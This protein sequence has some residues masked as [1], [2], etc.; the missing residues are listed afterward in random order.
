ME[1]AKAIASRLN[2]SP[3]AR[4]TIGYLATFSYGDASQPQWTGVVDAAR[5]HDVNLICFL[6][7]NLRS[8]TGLEAQGNILYDL[9]SPEN[10][11]G[12]VSWAS[13][14]GNYV[15]AD[16]IRIFHEH[17][18]PL[19]MVT[20]GKIL[21]GIPGLLMDSYE[22]MRDAIVHLIRDHGYR[23]IAF[24]RGPENHLYAQQRYHAYTE[25]LKAYGISLDP[26]L[27]TPHFSWE[28]FRGR[29]AMRLLLDERKLRPQTDFEAIAVA[30][31][32]LLLGALEVLRERG[33]RV[34]WDEAVVGFNDTFQGR[35]NIPPLTTVAVPFYQVGYQS[36]E[37]LLALLEG[38]SVPKQV[39]APSK[40][41]IRQSC[42]C[43][44]PAVA[45]A[46]IDPT[47]V[48]E[49]RGARV[50]AS[51]RDQILS[52]MTQAV[53]ESFENVASGWRDR[54]LDG[55]VSELKGEPSSSFLQELYEVLRQ[56]R[57]AGSDVSA[58]QGALSAL[59]QQVA[60]LLDDE[61]LKRAENLW[62]QARVAI[63]ETAKR[64][65]AYQAL[66]AGQQA[67]TLRDI[68]T[69]LI[70]TFDV[71][72]LMDVLAQDL[73]RLGI[74]SCYLAL[75]ENPLPYRYPQPAPEWSRLA[76]AFTEK[77]RI[78]LEPGGRRFRSREL[79]PAGML[80]QDRPLSLAVESLYFQDNQL[81]FVVVEI[82]P[83]DGAVYA[84]LRAQISSALQGA[85]LQHE[86]QRTQEALKTSQTQLRTI[87]DSL[88]VLIAQVGTDQRFRSVPQSGTQKNITLETRCFPKSRHYSYYTP[89]SE[90]SQYSE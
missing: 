78:P 52:A 68:G 60:P 74:P 30:N 69:A 76:L 7:R 55:F 44:D 33:I 4:R 90:Q 47:Q 38:Q 58:W 25:A 53:G 31:D 67:Q 80:P 62:Q 50:L 40:L 51:R 82:G 19:P 3:N 37:T 88:P 72:G 29:E 43:L 27:V 63:G 77:G 34:P 6:G 14:I 28:S 56:V 46:A 32:H 13:S 59:R 15:T 35:M 21:E 42:G 16:E 87:A 18:R 54:L 71:Q 10:V 86:R 48:S 24:I 75:Y 73:P 2:R 23:R 70:T 66:Q 39:V 85:L 12:V 45:Q 20:I 79:V 17:Y 81:G 36:V 8:P 64:V 26:N 83:Q 5:K 65:Q 41:M 49:E 22:G 57:A 84:A 1:N 11:D 9:V 61:T 89:Q